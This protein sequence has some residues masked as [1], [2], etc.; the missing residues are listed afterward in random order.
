MVF[1]CFVAHP[2]DGLGFS[3]PLLNLCKPLSPVPDWVTDLFA[4]YFI[5]VML[6]TA[7]QT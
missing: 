6:S 4:G 7:T 2:F 3:N 1:G 5:L